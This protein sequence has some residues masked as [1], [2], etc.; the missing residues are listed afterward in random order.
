MLVIDPQDVMLDETEIAG[1]LSVSVD[2]RA[3][4]VSVEFGDFGSQVVF[5]DVP[6]RRMTAKVVYRVGTPA[7]D[8]Q[9]EQEQQSGLLWPE[10]GRLSVLSFR[11]RRNNAGTGAKVLLR[12]VV[13]G[14]TH[15]LTARGGATRTVEMLLVSPGGDAVPI[16]E[17]LVS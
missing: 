11:T 13:T 7:R 8:E 14:V 16:E 3:E 15:D 10:L 1:V 9:A 17:T 6:R 2:Q 12:G 5:A 4:T